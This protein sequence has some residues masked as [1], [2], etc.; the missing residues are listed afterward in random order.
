MFTDDVRCR[1]WKQVQSR[2][3]R[4]FAEFLTPAVLAQAARMVGLKI[5]CC[6]LN[7]AHM[8][9][10]GLALAI[11]E[12]KSFA[13]VLSVTFKLLVDMGVPPLKLGPTQSS[14]GSGPRAKRKNG[15]ESRKPQRSKHDPR[16]ND[17]TKVTEEAF[18]KARKRMPLGYW[19][20]LVILLADR[21]ASE[22]DKVI[23][24]KTFRLLAMDGTLINLPERQSLA[25]F[26]GTANNQKGGR[27]PQA[28][29]VMMQFPLCRVPYRFTIGPKTKDEKGMAA[30]LLHHL[31]AKDLLLIDRGFWSFGLFCAIESRNAYFAIRQVAQVKLKFV[32]RLGPKD[33]LVQFAPSDPKW[34]KLKLPR[35]LTFRRIEY[36]IPGFRPSAI[37]TN[38]TDPKLISRRE[39]VGMATRHEA[40]RVLEN[41]IYH[42]RWEIETTFRE[43]KVS[44][45][46]KDVRSRT[47]KSVLYELASHVLLY[48]MVRWLMVKAASA[49]GGDPLRLSFENA[50]R[51]V[52]DMLPALIAKSHRWVETVLLPRLLDRI[53][54]H[55]VP[56]RPGRHYPR[57][58]DTKVINKGNG[59]KRVPSKMVA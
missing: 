44:Q 3:I 43:L 52:R 19:I 42:R 8:A 59:Q 50:L 31:V 28:R 58:N 51:E 49:H 22:H 1:V 39:W 21:F 37:I 35:A 30:E 16:S 32:K 9:W 38:L 20:A 25:K 48:L 23:R 29:M 34:R 13:S 55:H 18:V 36:Q 57:P 12:T 27:I 26:F 40:G 10:L 15:K 54:A 17:P 33:T 46:M 4:A 11:D 14:K 56:L 2:G 53:E 6:P 41:S 5:S 47:P 45:G 7:L 24:W